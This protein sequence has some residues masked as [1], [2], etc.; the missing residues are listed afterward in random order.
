MKST[1]AEEAFMTSLVGK[2]FKTFRWSLTPR[3]F[4]ADFGGEGGG[5]AD[6][7]LVLD[8]TASSGRQV[9]TFQF[10]CSHNGYYPHSVALVRDDSVDAQSL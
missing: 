1:A 4:N 5:D 9:V 7:E 10:W 8:S 6:V 2:P 3:T